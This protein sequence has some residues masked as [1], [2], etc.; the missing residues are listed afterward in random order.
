MG[1]D[2]FSPIPN[3]Q[4]GEPLLFVYPELSFSLFIATSPYLVALSSVLFGLLHRD[5]TVRECRV[6]GDMHTEFLLENLKGRENIS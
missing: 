2:C 5:G 4:N 6:Y 3:P 1:M